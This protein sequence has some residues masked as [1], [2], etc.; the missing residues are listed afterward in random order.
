MPARGAYDDLSPNDRGRVRIPPEISDGRL[1]LVAELH[2]LEHTAH[3]GGEVCR[4]PLMMLV[5]PQGDVLPDRERPEQRGTLEH[6]R[7]RRASRPWVA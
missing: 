1:P 7:C 2:E 4:R 5:E 6:Q 3:G